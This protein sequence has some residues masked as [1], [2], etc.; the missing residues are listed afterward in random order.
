[1][2]ASKIEIP[3]SEETK[4]KYAAHCA[5]SGSSM[6]VELRRHILAQVDGVTVQVPVSQQQWQRFSVAAQ[7]NGT[8]PEELLAQ[9]VRRVLLRHA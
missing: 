8:S 9:T 1:M 2:T 3:L 6:A 5:N 7:S 4:A